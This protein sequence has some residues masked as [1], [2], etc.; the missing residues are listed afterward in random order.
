MTKQEYSLKGL[1]KARKRKGMT[2]ERLAKKMGVHI[3]TVMNW[4]QS[5]VNPELPTIMELSELLDC[6]LDY[7]TGRL[8]EP[9]H[10]MSFVCEF[11]GLSAEAIYRLQAAKRYGWNKTI[12]SLVTAEGFKSL[13][14]DY[15]RFLSLVNSM[16]SLEVSWQVR[17]YNKILSTGIHLGNHVLI[18][19]HEAAKLYIKTVNDSITRICQEELAKAVKTKKLTVEAPEIDT[20]IQIAEAAAEELKELASSL[21]KERERK[22]VE[23][24]LEQAISS[25]E[26]KKQAENETNNKVDG[27]SDNG[28]H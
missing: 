19:T 23:R 28:Q 26:E 20:E 5:I 22:E 3:K 1:K 7:L 17:D 12:D 27:G 21:K 14:E 24:Q 9:T 8:S 11:T 25:Y 16:E 10:D 15:S 6:D 2:Q 4:E 18:S 13:V